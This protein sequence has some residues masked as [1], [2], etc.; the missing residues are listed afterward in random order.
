VGFGAFE[1]PTVPPQLP[2]DY[3]LDGNVAAADYV[4]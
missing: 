2:D 4:V 1:A 3:N